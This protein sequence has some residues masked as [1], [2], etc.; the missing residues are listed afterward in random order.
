MK[1]KL[2]KD[3]SKLEAKDTL[4]NLCNKMG[5]GLDFRSRSNIFG[6]VDE[7]VKSN[8]IEFPT[9]E[10][11]NYIHYRGGFR[12]V[13]GKFNRDVDIEI[14]NGV[15]SLQVDSGG[16]I[17]T[18]RKEMSQFLWAIAYFL[19]SDQEWAEDKYPAL[20]KQTGE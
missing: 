2:I 5:I 16:W 14:N 18:T 10:S 11:F 12:G 6:K 1:D 15:V 17:E 19:D 9:S 8:I 7:L 3:M 20:N 4:S 13:T